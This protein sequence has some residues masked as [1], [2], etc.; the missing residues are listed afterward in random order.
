MAQDRCGREISLCLT[1][2]QSIMNDS[3]LLFAQNEKQL[4]LL[5]RYVSLP[6]FLLLLPSSPPSSLSLW[7]DT[8]VLVGEAR[9]QLR[10]LLL[11]NRM[12]HSGFPNSRLTLTTRDARRGTKN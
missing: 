8:D 4:D 7:G 6:L 2:L 12:T 10:L 11:H 5:C 3:K 1:D 9:L